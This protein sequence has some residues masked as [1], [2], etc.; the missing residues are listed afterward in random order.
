MIGIRD[1]VGVVRIRV[2]TL[3][4]SI[5]SC[6]CEIPWSRLSRVAGVEGIN[7]VRG[8]FEVACG[9]PTGLIKA[10]PLK[11]VLSEPVMES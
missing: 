2:V 3:A 1:I 4:P 9:L 6:S 5:G 11:F 10:Y 7:S 8:V